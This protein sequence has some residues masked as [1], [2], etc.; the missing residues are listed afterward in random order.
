MICLTDLTATAAAITGAKLSTGAAEDSYSILPAL[1]GIPCD[2][3]IREATIHHSSKGLFA[4][5]QGKW[6]LLDHEGSGGNRYQEKTAPLQLYDLEADASETRNVY[7]QQPEVVDRLKNLLESYQAAGR[8]RP[9]TSAASALGTATE[10]GAGTEF[11]ILD[12]DTVV[13]L[14]DSITAARTYGKFI[15]N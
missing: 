12:G 7:D 9:E 15:G 6:V 4:V 1:L 14:G 10:P 13:F 3:P 8:S 2:A 11:A 5:R